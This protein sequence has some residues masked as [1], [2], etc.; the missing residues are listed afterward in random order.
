[1]T[2]EEFFKRLMDFAKQPERRAIPSEMLAFLRGLQPEKV[3]GIMERCA[4]LPPF[5]AQ[6]SILLQLLSLAPASHR[7]AALALVETWIAAMPDGEMKNSHRLGLASAI[8]DQDPLKAISLVS[9]IPGQAGSLALQNIFSQ[10]AKR[11]RQAAAAQIDRLTDERLRRSA[12]LGCAKALAESS[13]Q[14][15]LDLLVAQGVDNSLPMAQTLVGLFAGWI[16]R[17]PQAAFSYLK[18]LPEGS[19]RTQIVTHLLN[20][21][22]LIPPSDAVQFLELFPQGPAKDQW[23]SRLTQVWSERDSAGAIQWANMQTDKEVRAKGLPAMAAGLAKTNPQAAVQMAL[24]LPAPHRAE[25]LPG[26]ARA[27]A[28]KDPKAA[29]DFLQNFPVSEEWVKLQAIKHVLERWASWDPGPASQWIGRMPPGNKRDQVA[30]EFAARSAE[31]DPQSAS[32]AALSIGNVEQRSAALEKLGQTWIQNDPRGARAWVMQAPLSPQQ[33]EN[34]L[35]N[36]P[37][38]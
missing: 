21:N 33:R 35:R 9:K 29:A 38:R 24:G 10:W 30:S 4:A 34:I 20:Y 18:Q 7:P 28:D 17:E 15:A 16:K 3:S 8:A 26:I 13:P 23:L 11:D 31:L 2:E 36:D 1:M 25:A 6:G 37:Y 5:G 22:H 14:A 12:S 19:D 27:W 32:L